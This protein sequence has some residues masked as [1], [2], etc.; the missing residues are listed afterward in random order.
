MWGI[1]GIEVV[2]TTTR[3]LVSVEITGIVIDCVIELNAH[4]T[5]EYRLG[6]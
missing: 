1:Y 3:Y 5:R 4:S 6:R 2:L